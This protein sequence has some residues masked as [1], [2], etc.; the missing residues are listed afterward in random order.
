M[1]TRLEQEV[2][3]Q[4]GQQPSFMT[5]LCAHTQVYD[6]YR[7]AA[8]LADPSLWEETPRAASPA[9]SCSK[10]MTWGKCLP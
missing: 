5:V 10:I 3:L 1:T 2:L 8:P 6:L 7:V 9:Q 4:P